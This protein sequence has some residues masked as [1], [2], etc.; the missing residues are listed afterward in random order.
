MIIQNKSATKCTFCGWCCKNKGH[1]ILK[2]WNFVV[3]CPPLSKFLATCL[4]CFEY[5]DTI[6]GMR[7]YQRSYWDSWKLVGKLDFITTKVKSNQIL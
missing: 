6:D 5:I 2:C 4:V 1:Y 3:V 7:L